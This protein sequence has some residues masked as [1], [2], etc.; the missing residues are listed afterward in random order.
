MTEKFSRNT[1]VENEFGSDVFSCMIYRE[2]GD[3]VGIAHGDST[4]EA[5]KIA[6]LFAA[7]GDLLEALESWFTLVNNPQISAETYWREWPKMKEH[8]AAA[9]AKARGKR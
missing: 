8:I 4:A 6:D 3:S 7:S 9:I 5:V 1:M 2:N